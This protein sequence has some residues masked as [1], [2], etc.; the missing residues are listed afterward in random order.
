MNDKGLMAKIQ[1][2]LI[3]LNIN[4]RNN[5][6][7]KQAKDLSRHFS[8]KEHAGGQQAHEN[9]LNISNYQRNATQNWNEISP[10]ILECLSSKRT[11]ITDP[12]L[13]VQNVEKKES[14]YFVGENIN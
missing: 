13:N 9:M 12:G 1:K 10:H 14:S 4:N 6:L 2:K 11:Q 7:K 5:L 8:K 3:K